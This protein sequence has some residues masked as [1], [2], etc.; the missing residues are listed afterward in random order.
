MPL[1]LS[2]VVSLP[3]RRSVWGNSKCALYDM[4]HLPQIINDVIGGNSRAGSYLPA[5]ARAHQQGSGADPP[6]QFDIRSPIADHETG[7]L[8]K[9]KLLR[10]PLQQAGRGFATETMIF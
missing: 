3:F 4:C 2:Q 9:P 10:R 7:L 8:I 1:L 5:I 6:S